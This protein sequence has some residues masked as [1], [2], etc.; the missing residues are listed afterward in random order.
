MPR[1][2]PFVA[3]KQRL[4]KALV[5]L[6]EQEALI[7]LIRQAVDLYELKPTDLFSEKA[8]AMAAE[9]V[10]PSIPYCDRAGNTWSGKGRRPNWLVQAIDAG[11]ALEDFRN[12]AYTG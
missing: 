12:P 10:D 7:E 9:Q 11:A 8:L 4:E 3:M 6:A 5:E 1:V 2:K